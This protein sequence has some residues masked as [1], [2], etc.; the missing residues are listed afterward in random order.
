MDVV[1]FDLAEE[2]DKWRI[3]VNIVMKFSSVE[4]AGNFLTSRGTVSSSR[5]NFFHEVILS[6]QSLELTSSF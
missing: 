6:G 5:R 4:K 3:V 1:W 2:Q